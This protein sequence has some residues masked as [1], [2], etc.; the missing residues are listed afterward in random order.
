[1]LCC[2]A[3]AIVGPSLFHDGRQWLCTLC[4]SLCVTSCIVSLLS[5]G[6]I[7]VNRYVYICHHEAYRRFFAR[8]TYVAIVAATWVIGVAID[9]PS[10]AGWSVHTFDRKTQK[11]L[12][13]RTL[14]HQYTIFFVTVGMILPLSIIVL[15]YWRIFVHIRE[16]KL[17]ILQTRRAGGG[18]IGAW[19]TQAAIVKTIRQIKVIVLIFIAF[20]ICW[21]PYAVVLL[22]DEY[23]VFPLSVHLYASMIAHLHASVNFFIY[24]L[25]NKGLRTAYHDFVVRRLFGLCCAAMAVDRTASTDQSVFTRSRVSGRSFDTVRTSRPNR[26]TIVKNH[27]SMV[28]N[29]LSPN[30]LPGERI[31]DGTTNYRDIVCADC[32]ENARQQHPAH[33]EHDTGDVAQVETSTP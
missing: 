29:D 24:G 14:S 31:E 6:C 30:Q 25:T 33:T 3:G 12:W 17:R 4:A 21:A 8:Y 16:A 9:A 26:K 11:C 23:D 7:S 19:T 15:C 13:D 27:V 18:A 22:S 32:V 1:M 5:I 28:M 10:H 2:V 20:C